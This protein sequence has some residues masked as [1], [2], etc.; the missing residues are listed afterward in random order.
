MVSGVLVLGV[1]VST[2]QAARATR[3]ETLA[4]QRLAESE[5][6]SKFLTE[7]FQSP[8]PARD[9]RTIT[10]AE[11]L[12]AAARRLDNGS[13]QPARAPGQTPGHSR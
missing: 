3:A 4:K 8:D 1:I 5:A 11:A 12:G 6:I 13:G 2:W 9:G 7:V 10:V